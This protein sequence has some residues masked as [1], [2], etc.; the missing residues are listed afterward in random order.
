MFS[1]EPYHIFKISR[2]TH[3]DQEIPAGRRYT[4]NGIVCQKK[5]IT[6]ISVIPESVKKSQLLTLGLNFVFV[7][8][9]LEVILKSILYCS[10]LALII[11][12]SLLVLLFLFGADRDEARSILI[13]A[14]WIIA[15][16][17]IIGLINSIYSLIKSIQSGCYLSTD[18]YLNVSSAADPKKAF[19]SSRYKK[20]CCLDYE[21]LRSQGEME[22]HERKLRVHLVLEDNTFIHTS[23]Y[24]ETIRGLWICRNCRTHLDDSIKIGNYCPG[25]DRKINDRIY[26]IH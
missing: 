25:C 9:L 6:K 16:I 4:K 18:R 11:L 23:F 24:E 8:E 14:L 21:V 10:K 12:T 2:L 7:G 1:K 5:S 19:R 3:S 15:I 22:L 13:V 26:S 17:Y 20:L